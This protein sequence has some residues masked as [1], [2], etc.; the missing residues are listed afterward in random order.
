MSIY[1]YNANGTFSFHA[2]E[3]DRYAPA[4]GEIDPGPPQEDE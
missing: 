4:C 1:V 3:I 2:S